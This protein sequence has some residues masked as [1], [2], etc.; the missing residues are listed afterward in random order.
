MGY[1]EK[2]A[3]SCPKWQGGIAV[4]HVT[5]NGVTL[6]L[7][8]VHISLHQSLYNRYERLCFVPHSYGTF[9]FWT[10]M[11]DSILLVSQ[12]EGNTSHASL[13]TYLRIQESPSLLLRLDEENNAKPK[14]R[15]TSQKKNPHPISN[16][17][18]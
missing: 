17:T 2:A 9:S 16:S 15:G 12:E 3:K 7:S 5:Q 13:H 4:G 1:W 10:P 8:T 11:R 18:K 6:F 14:A